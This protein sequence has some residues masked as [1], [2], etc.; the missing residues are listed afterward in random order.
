[1]IAVCY[2]L[3]Y[4]F[5]IPAVWNYSIAFAAEIVLTFAAYELIRRIPILRYFVPGLKKKSR[6]GER[7]KK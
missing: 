1:M 2:V 7:E 4:Y 3:C 6:A 5:D